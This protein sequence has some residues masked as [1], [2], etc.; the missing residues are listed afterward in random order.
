MTLQRTSDALLEAIGLAS[1]RE[2]EKSIFHNDQDQDRCDA[3]PWSL[4]RR[5]VAE[6][7]LTSPGG[8][9]IPGEDFPMETRPAGQ[10]HKTQRGRM[11]WGERCVRVERKAG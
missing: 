3:N 5:P 2:I 1:E 11:R 9:C 6:M 8:Y 7:S 4:L 10:G